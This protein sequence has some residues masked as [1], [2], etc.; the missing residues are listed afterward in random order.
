MFG[1]HKKI[2]GIPADQV[3]KIMK[4]PKVK[5]AVDAK[6]AK[7]QSFWKSVSPVF[8]EGDPREHRKMPAHGEPGDYQKSITVVPMPDDSGYRDRVKPTDFKAKWIE[9]GTKHM[10]PYA[11]LAK[12]KAEFRK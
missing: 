10:P 1:R 4:G 2:K 11:P 5:A 6:A 7:V 9:F 12:V 8:K 3:D